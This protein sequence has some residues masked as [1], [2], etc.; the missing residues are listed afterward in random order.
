V[1]F[2]GRVAAHEREGLGVVGVSSPRAFGSC[3]CLERRINAWNISPKLIHRPIFLVT[4]ERERVV[5]NESGL[6]PANSGKSNTACH[7][8]LLE[9]VIFSDVMMTVGKRQ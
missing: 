4:N 6:Y 7:V 1:A 9:G 8:A 3:C 2:W 5:L